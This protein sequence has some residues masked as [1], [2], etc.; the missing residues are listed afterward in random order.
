MSNS[1]MRTLPVTRATGLV[2]CIRLRQRTNVDLPQPEGPMR[3]VAWLAGMCRV[4]SKRVWLAPY[5]AFRCS[6]WIPTP[7]SACPFQHAA[8][9][10]VP[11]QGDGKHDQK[12]QNQRAGP[13]QAVPLLVRRDGVDVNLQWQGGD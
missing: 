7:I 6:T 4:M 5:H 3:A 2:S 12:N 13:C 11:D 9:G 10:H 8:R 1:P